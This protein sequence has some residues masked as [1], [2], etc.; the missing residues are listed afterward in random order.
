MKRHKLILLLMIPLLLRPLSAAADSAGPKTRVEAS[1]YTETSSYGEVLAFLREIQVRSDQV[2]VRSLTTSAEG[3]M[4]PLVIVSRESISDPS[5]RAAIPKPAVLVMANIH[6]GEVEGKE[7][8]LMMIR[9]L[10]VGPLRHLLE[11]QVLLFLPIYNADGNDRFGHNRRDDGPELAGL[12]ANGQNLDLN[13]DYMKLEAPETRGLLS[14]FRA[15]DPILTVDMHTTNGSYHREPVTYAGMAHPSTSRLLQDYFWQKLTAGAADALQSKYGYESV[16]YGNF[17][18]RL[19]PEKGWLNDAMDARYGTNY[20]GLRNRFALLDENYSYADFKTRVLASYAYLRSILEFTDRHIGEMAE[21]AYRA[22]RET[23]RDYAR[24]KAAVE[25]KIE[26]LMKV[27]VRSYEFAREEM[28]AA[29]SPAERGG[30]GRYRLRRTE[31]L[32]DYRIP[33]FS[34]AVPTR[35]LPLPEEG[36]VILPGQAEAIAILRSHGILLEKFAE[37]LRVTEAENFKIT[38]MELSRTIYQGRIALTLRGEYQKGEVLIPENAYFI[39][40]HQPLARLVPLLLEPE[41]PDSLAAW[42]FF[43]RAI[44]PQWSNTFSLYPVYRLARRPAVAM[45]AE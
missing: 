2:R 18:D 16:P 11:R 43:N 28:P 35:V 45:V 41:I 31:T 22:D 37:P 26:E 27:T 24:E 34:L 5:Q 38:A 14:L 20:I 12:R 36:Y 23:A 40:L 6:A 44:V 3:R 30:P 17:M 8:S 19:Q 25:F 21:L 33:Y 9:D 7:S 42:G 10:A 1:G 39:S 13:R 15:W 29:G 32:R 4:V